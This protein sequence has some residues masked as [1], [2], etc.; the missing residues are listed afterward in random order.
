MD[1][2][3]W[4]RIQTLFHQ[5]ADLPK[6]DQPGF[7]KSACDGDDSLVADVLALLQEDSQ[8][9]SPLDRGLAQVARDVFDEGLPSS[10][11]FPELGPY[12]V[13]KVLGE[14]GMGVVYLAE[15][16]DLGSM[17][18][19]KLLRDAWLS[20]AR[21]ERFAAEQRTLA[22]LNHPSI[23]RIYDADTLPD[24]TPYFV[25]EYVEGL[26]LTDY[27]TQHHCSVE[28]RLQLFR[29]V[30]EAVQDAHSHAVIH[31]DLKPSNILVK[32]DGTIRLLDFGIAKQVES[33]DM[34]A[35]QTMTGL[36]LMT[37]AYA[38]P[39]QIRGQR[40]G[41][42]TDVYSLGVILYELLAGQL[43]F[44]LSNLAPTEAET[45]LIEH[46]PGKPS[47]A[48]KR[49]AANSRVA[50]PS[51]SSW[52]DLD[53]LCLTAMHKDPERRYRSV[54]AL[55]RDIDHYL[56]GEPLDAR[57]DTLSYRLSKFVR[58]NRS[59]VTAAAVALTVLVGMVVFFT[60]RLQRARD[61]AL[62]EA[63]RAQRV[64]QFMMTLFQ[65]GDTS[66]GTSD[67]LKVVTLIDHGAQQARALDADPKVQV[68]LYETLGSAYE[69]LGKFD[70][71]Q[72]LFQAAFDK[73]KAVFG[74]ESPE[75]AESM[76]A[77]GGLKSDQAEYEESEKSIREALAISKKTLPPNHPFFA[78]ATA[79]LGALLANRGEYDQAILVLNEAAQLQVATGASQADQGANLTE[80]ANAHFYRGDYDI[81]DSLNRRVLEMDRQ[82][83]GNRHPNVGEDLINLGALQ[84]QL[85]H[86]PE[87]EHYQRQALDI[88]QSFFGKDHPETASVM[89]AL[90]RALVPQGRLDEAGDM[91]RQA[92]AIQERVYGPVHP[93]VAAAL[94]EIGKVEQQRG[95]LDEAE[96]DFR[97]MADIYRT[98][99]HG[100]HYYIGNALSNLAG[101]ALERKKYDEAERLVR[102]SLQMYAQ[103]LPA[104]HQLVGISRIRLGRIFLR[105]KRY[106]E[107]ETESLAG[108]GILAKQESAPAAW[109]LNARTDLAEEYDALRQ[110]EQA[111]KYRAELTA[112]IQKNPS[113]NKKN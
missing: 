69:G 91:L 59:E 57:P 31:R 1:S 58:R 84:F 45:V 71:A 70:Q 3:L 29:Q 25:M 105:Q 50:L 93:R 92:L 78:K 89:T 103:T 54:E 48:A 47:T 24:G 8:S 40:L 44:D 27:C 74:A 9:S 61:T 17:V 73:S 96:A 101:V 33:L 43:P 112:A 52:A 67:D 32:A 76:L 80:L 82:I 34:P 64:Q 28:R 46:D 38:S 79:A 14:G 22:Q 108:Y 51:A 36:R 107:A 13:R 7:L 20:P 110:P 41:I 4:E 53:V 104:D 87:A 97:R 35:Q 98:V 100:K 99:Y 60:V 55:T 81:A 85:G 49:A 39:E 42:Q 15:R 2:N 113:A 37:P 88:I 26:P 65:G 94:A 18:A 6:A 102:E 11:P 23:A 10:L 62:A 21:R 16:S 5:A 86:Y 66:V 72:S 19:V 90:G 106:A 77:L 83:Y 56:R 75:V 68:D 12:R 109:M 111:A 63:A 30:C 95:K